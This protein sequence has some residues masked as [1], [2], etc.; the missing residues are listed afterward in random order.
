MSGRTTTATQPS[1][2][3][4]GADS[5]RGACGQISFMPTPSRAP[6]HTTARMMSPVRPVRSSTLK[7]V[8]VP[9]MN[10]KIIE[11]SRRRISL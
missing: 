10:T 2:M 6:P 1:A 7:G 4:S 3:Y 9:A 11:W 8:Y 5:H